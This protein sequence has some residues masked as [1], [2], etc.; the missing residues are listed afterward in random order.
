MDI[1]HMGSM[2]PEYG[3]LKGLRG[4]NVSDRVAPMLQA[5]LDFG[6]EKSGGLLPAS[7]NALAGSPST[8]S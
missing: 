1:A 4:P 7:I 2:A 5:V 3:Y 6:R 8:S